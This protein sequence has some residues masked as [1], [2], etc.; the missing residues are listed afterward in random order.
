MW[1]LREN[2]LFERSHLGL[3][4]KHAFIL[5]AGRGRTCVTKMVKLKVQNGVWHPD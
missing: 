5:Q 3:Q 2:N 4:D 1:L